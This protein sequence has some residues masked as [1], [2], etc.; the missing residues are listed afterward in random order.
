MT[1]SGGHVECL[2]DVAVGT[3]GAPVW[4]NSPMNRRASNQ[5]TPTAPGPTASDA[6][7]G[8]R[9]DV[10]LDVYWRP[11]CPF[12]GML[13]RSLRKRGLEARFHNIWEDPDAAATVR[14]AAGGNETVPTV[15]VAGHMLVNPRIG[16]VE[17][18]L[19]KVSSGELTPR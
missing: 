1:C 19:A 11:G 18:L 9:S 15:S 2:A 4:F 10:L 12:C 14:A 16:L 3:I 17:E 7:G 13:K 8:A 6:A 5:D